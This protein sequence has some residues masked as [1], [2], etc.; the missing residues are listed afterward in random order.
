MDAEPMCSGES[1]G[2]AAFNDAARWA[3]LL[4][5]RSSA[6]RL[7]AKRHGVAGFAGGVDAAAARPWPGHAGVFRSR[8]A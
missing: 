3:D 8:V 5:E 6:L 2:G 7:F 1:N 4:P